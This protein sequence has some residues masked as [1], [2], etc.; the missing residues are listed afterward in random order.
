MLILYFL[1]AGMPYKSEKHEKNM[2]HCGIIATYWSL[3]ILL[4]LTLQSVLFDKNILQP[5][6]KEKNSFSSSILYF[7]FALLFDIV[8]YFIIADS[9]FITIFTFD[10]IYQNNEDSDQQVLNTDNEQ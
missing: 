10:L 1:Y 6:L 7:T 4:K 9:Q 2:K 8:P 5:D 3:S